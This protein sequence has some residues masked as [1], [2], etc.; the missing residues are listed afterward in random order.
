M[1]YKP[2]Q[3]GRLWDTW[4]YSHNGV[5]YLYHL[6]TNCS[7]GEAIGLAT[8]NDGVHWQE[9]GV[10]FK[11]ADEAAWLGTGSIW[12]H[13]TQLGRFVMNFSEWLGPF[14]YGGQEGQ[15]VIRFAVSDD[16]IH[17]T[18]LGSNFDFAPDARWYRKDEGENSRWDC[19][20]SFEEKGRR[21]G[22]WTA[23]PK[24]FHPGVGFGVSDDGLQWEA[25]APPRFEWIGT[26]VMDN[27]EAGAVE[28][29]G[30]EYWML[31]G[32]WSHHEGK[33]GVVTFVASKPEGPFRPAQRNFFLLASPQKAAY[34]ARFFPH[35][36]EM[37]VNHHVMTCD[38]A[39]FF[40]PLKRAVR[41][42]NGTLRLH[43]WPQNEAAKGEPINVSV[44]SKTSRSVEINGHTLQLFAAT[45]PLAWED[46]L[47]FETI[48]ARET[49]AVGLAIACENDRMLA[50]LLQ[51]DNSVLFGLLDANNRWQGEDCIQRDT[52][53]GIAPRV[54]LLVHETLFELYLQDVLI[55]CYHLPAPPT[56]E[57]Q[58]LHSHNETRPK[59]GAWHMKLCVHRS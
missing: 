37:L 12:P 13:P 52:D 32:T 23:H 48:F 47:W 57:L 53:F 15:Q 45:A 39:R 34:F 58:W 16:L 55:H 14:N 33:F 25:L 46:G 5:F 59:V 49:G 17:W 38:D 42:E 35:E 21:Y 9:R 22:Y 54:R 26:S 11:K 28:R 31:A 8:S 43:F 2:Q 4:M 41:D 7:P 44:Q 40:A 30:I 24:A 36:N 20:Y 6:V 18:R 3:T 10:I 50:L 51:P 19:I 27:M 29:I 1:F 56:G